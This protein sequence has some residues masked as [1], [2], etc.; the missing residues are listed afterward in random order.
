[1]AASRLTVLHRQTLHQ[2]HDVLC[3][4]LC[5]IASKLRFG[6]A[7][8]LP[9]SAQVDGDQWLSVETSAGDGSPGCGRVGEAVQEE[10]RASVWFS[11][12]LHRQSCGEVGPACPSSDFAVRHG[13]PPGVDIGFTVHATDAS[14]PLGQ[15]RPRRYRKTRQPYANPHPRRWA[16]RPPLST[17]RSPPL[18]DGPGRAPLTSPRALPARLAAPGITTCANAVPGKPPRRCDGRARS[19]ELTSTSAVPV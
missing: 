13:R 7:R 14:E 6:E 5:G 17:V 2:P 4:H 9:V 8:G 1:M 11:C 19:P 3:H 10:H 16:W 18:S 12:L 15:G